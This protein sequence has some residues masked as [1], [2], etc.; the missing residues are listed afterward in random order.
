MVRSGDIPLS[1]SDAVHGEERLF[2]V[3]ER[4]NSREAVD[5]KFNHVFIRIQIQSNIDSNPK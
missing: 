3:R 4:K 1:P 2:I 5:T